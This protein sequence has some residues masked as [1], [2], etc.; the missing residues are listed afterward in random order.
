MYHL[1][2]E[3]KG[4]DVQIWEPANLKEIIV[5]SNGTKFWNVF[6]KGY[7]NVYAEWKRPN[8]ELVVNSTEFSV[9]HIEPKPGQH[10]MITQ[11]HIHNPKLQQAGRYELYVSNERCST[12][13]FFNLIVNGKFF[14]HFT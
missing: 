3:A 10:Y 1:I 14:I 6:Y 4:C 12:T 13:E 11:L 8:E 9:A 7:P 5:E 2:A